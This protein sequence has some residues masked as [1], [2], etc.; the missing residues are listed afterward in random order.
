MEDLL[1]CRDLYDPLQAKGKNP[2]PSKDTTWKILNRKV[3]D[4]IKQ[5]IDHSVFHY[6]AQ[7]TNAYPLEETK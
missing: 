7:K 3:I 5:W 4:Q 6:V 1:S 2:N